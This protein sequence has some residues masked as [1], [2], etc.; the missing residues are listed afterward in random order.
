ML[1]AH[2][3]DEPTVLQ[4]SKRLLKEFQ[5]RLKAARS[6]AETAEE[7]KAG[8]PASPSVDLDD[9]EELLSF[10]VTHGLRRKV[11]DTLSLETFES[12]EEFLSFLKQKPKGSRP[13]PS[14]ILLDLKLDGVDEQSGLRVLDKVKQN[15]KL[16]KV[17][18]VM[19]TTH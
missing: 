15:K 7:E 10:W 6:K 8:E 19:L 14:L 3:D 13:K 5:S 2:I 1:I 17:P 18:V 4:N 12:E 11:P 9:P 16:G